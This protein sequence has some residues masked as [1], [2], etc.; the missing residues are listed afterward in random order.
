MK[1][2]DIKR[3]VKAELSKEY[4]RPV[5]IPSHMMK[6]PKAIVFSSLI[7]EYKPM[8]LPMPDLPRAPVPQ[9]PTLPMTMPQAQQQPVMPVPMPGGGMD[10]IASLLNLG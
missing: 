3:L 9:M 7:E 4:G 10:D 6:K 5:D 2:K 8:D 1:I